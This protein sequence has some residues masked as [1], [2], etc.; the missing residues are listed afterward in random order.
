MNVKEKIWLSVTV[1]QLITLLINHI[2]FTFLT[3]FIPKQSERKKFSDFNCDVVRY[4]SGVY[5]ILTLI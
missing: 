5:L 3:W 4:S 1:N 2:V